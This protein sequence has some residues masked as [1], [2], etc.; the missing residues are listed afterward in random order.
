MCGVHEGQLYRGK[1]AKESTSTK[2]HR[3]L[4]TKVMVV[5][6]PFC[7][8]TFVEPRR[9]MLEAYAKIPGGKESP[10]REAPSQLRGK[11]ARGILPH[12]HCL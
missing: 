5:Q 1:K 8:F 3:R 7:Y 2:V 6:C 10:A 11:S 12:C 4:L 9:P